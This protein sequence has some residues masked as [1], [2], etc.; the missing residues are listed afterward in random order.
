M[1]S[2]LNDLLNLKIRCQN[3][4]IK[5]VISSYELLINLSIPYHQGMW[6]ASH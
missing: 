5:H 6:S 2:C 1:I 4:K 3:I